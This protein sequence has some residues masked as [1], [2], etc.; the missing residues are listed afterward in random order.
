MAPLSDMGF[1]KHLHA[2]RGF[3]I[4]N[5]TAIHAFTMAI[6]FLIPVNMTLPSA[7]KTAINITVML[8]HDATL[9]FS[10]ISGLLFAAVLK[11]RSWHD[12]FKGKLLNVLSPY[13]VMTAVFSLVVWPQP[14]EGFQI[15][16]FRGAVG[17][18]LALT[19][20][21][22]LTGRSLFPMYYIPILTAL[23][24]A[25]PLINAAADRA[26]GRWLVLLL[27]LLPLVVSRTDL[28]VTASSVIYF[29]GAYAL[30]ILAGRDY[31]RWLGWVDGHLALLTGVVVVSSAVLLALLFGEIEFAGP[32]SLQESAFYVQKLAVAAIVLALLRRGEAQLPRWLDVTATYSFAIYFLH[33]PVQ[34]FMTWGLNQFATRYPNAIETMLL[35]LVFVVVPIGVS[36]AAAF[37]LRAALGKRSRMIIGT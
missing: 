16:P 14:M 21:N 36:I 18:Y 23:F 22:I 8:F 29:M 27:A 15:V 12:F 26:R 35:G 28:E 9:Y 4:I 33:G 17:D 5:I 6:Y 20:S 7:D 24:L 11:G 32:V 31:Q 34:F 25:T 37:L 3:A 13:I 19:G 1:I 30:G 10:L 2:F